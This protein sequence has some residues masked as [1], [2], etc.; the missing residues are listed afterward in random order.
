MLSVQM[1]AF[2]NTPGIYGMQPLSLLAAA[3]AIFLST[4]SKPTETQRILCSRPCWPPPACATP[5]TSR[6]RSP[7]STRR[8]R[9][10]AWARDLG[11]SNLAALTAYLLI[12]EHGGPLRVGRHGRQHQ[13]RV[14]GGPL[15]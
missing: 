9:Q 6:P 15:R 7:H 1:G 10:K 4:P 14:R 13:G 11:A 5:P 3:T 8:A 2:T 12:A